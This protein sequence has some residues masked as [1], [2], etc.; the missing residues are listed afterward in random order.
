V[1]T[2]PLENGTVTRRVRSVELDRKPAGPES[3]DSGFDEEPA[4][5]WDPR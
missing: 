5:A 4:Y 2:V 1:M 3:A